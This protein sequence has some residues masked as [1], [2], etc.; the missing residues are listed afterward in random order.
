[1]NHENLQILVLGSGGREHTLAKIC[2]QSPLVSDV[3][4]APG[5]GGM[6]QEF[7]SRPFPW[8]TMMLIIS[9]SAKPL[10]WWWL[11]LVLVQWVI[12]TSNLLELRHMA[13]IQ[14]VQTG[15]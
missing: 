15:G 4:V 14:N 9:S 1:M 11:A 13:R 10:I 2:A 6:D 7:T 12:G 3:L 8:K 5:N